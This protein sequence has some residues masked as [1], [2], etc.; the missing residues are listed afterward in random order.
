MAVG[1][2]MIL[3]GLAAAAHSGLRW[4]S[5]QSLPPGLYWASPVT[6]LRIGVIVEF[7][8][9]PGRFLDT[10]MSRGY[11]G[12]GNCPGGVLPLM[13]KVAALPGDV[14]DIDAG[15]VRVNSQ[16]WP[17]SRP[18]PQDRR[19]RPLPTVRLKGLRL[20]PGQW[21]PMSDHSP[22]SFDGRYSG[23]IDQRVILAT[24]R[25]LLTW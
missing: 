9:P 8:A 7:C 25:P 2:T 23:P 22:T 3:L 13:K 21:L 20:A 4:N 17:R 11:L 12:N 15:G 14:I 1:G 10:G 19:G 5:T 18:L 6:S 24:L 16:L